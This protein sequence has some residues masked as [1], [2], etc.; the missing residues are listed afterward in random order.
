MWTF[1]NFQTGFWQSLWFTVPWTRLWPT[2][3]TW[4]LNVK[5]SWVTSNPTF[6][7][8]N[9]IRSMAP[10]KMKTKI[11]TFTSYRYKHSW[12]RILRKKFHFSYNFHTLKFFLLLCQALV[13]FT[14]FFWCTNHTM[15]KCGNKW[16]DSC[17]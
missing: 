2:W 16:R 4:S 11:H 14:F 7:G 3:M 6:S 1:M 10:L 8:S 12:K 9:T 13:L 5:W 17:L 15:S